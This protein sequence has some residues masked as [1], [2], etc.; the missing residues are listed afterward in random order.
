MGGRETTE[1][2]YTVPVRNDACKPTCEF[3][4]G[5]VEDRIHAGR[6]QEKEVSAGEREKVKRTYRYTD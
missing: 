2:T 4:R 3:N 1:K 6:V 5:W